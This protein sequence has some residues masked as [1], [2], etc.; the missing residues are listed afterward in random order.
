MKVTGKIEKKGFG[1]GVWALVAD[2][3]TTYELKDPPSEL[4]KEGI[5]VEIEGKIRKDIMTMAMIGPV[6]EI[7]SYKIK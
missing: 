5:K 1:F 6:L 2:D 3:G 4:K 7:A